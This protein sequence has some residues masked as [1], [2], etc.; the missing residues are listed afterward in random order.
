MGEGENES[1]IPRPIA[2]SC[3]CERQSGLVQSVGVQSRIHRQ[4]AQNTMKTI[5]QSE[6][7]RVKEDHVFLF[8]LHWNS[9]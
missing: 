8:S 7:T 4:K 9:C 1:A 5:Q 3:C 6:R 2:L